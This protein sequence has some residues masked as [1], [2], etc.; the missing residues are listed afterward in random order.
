MKDLRRRGAD[1]AIRNADPGDPEL[2]ARRL[3]DDRGGPFA[4]PPLLA[5][6]SPI[7]TV[8]D[9]SSAPSVGLEDA[10]QLI[11]ALGTRGIALDAANFPV[12]TGRSHLAHW[13]RMRAGLDVGAGMASLAA[14]PGVIRLLPEIGFAFP[15]RLVAAPE[16]RTSARVR[17]VFDRLAA[18][19]TARARNLFMGA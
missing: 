3:P 17:T 13:A 6:I 11:A 2:I 5:R 10:S 8:A 4:A 15:V 12:T 19:L 9:L 14:E 16:L 7:R 18:A 1:I